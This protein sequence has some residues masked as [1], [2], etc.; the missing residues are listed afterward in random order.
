MKCFYV[1]ELIIP[2]ASPLAHL[3]N[4]L[5]ANPVFKTLKKAIKGS[6]IVHVYQPWPLGSKAQKIGKRL[7]IPVIRAFHIQSKN[8]TYNIG[9]G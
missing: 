4:T 3:Q 1:P 7:G 8:I 6:D 9:L 5:F 2:I